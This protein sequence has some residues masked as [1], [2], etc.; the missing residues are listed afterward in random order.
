M[1]TGFRIISVILTLVILMQCMVSSFAAFDDKS[2]TKEEWG[3][4]FSSH[5]N[6]NGVKQYSIG[7]SRYSAVMLMP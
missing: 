2:M 5:W 1:K 6:F 4:Y 7:A 3:Q